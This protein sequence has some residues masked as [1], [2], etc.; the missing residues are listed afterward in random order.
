MNEKALVVVVGANIEIEIITLRMKF[1]NSITC[2]SVLRIV[3]CGG[4]FFLSCVMVLCLASVFFKKE[5]L[6]HLGDLVKG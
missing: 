6:L 4:L 3:S 5:D 2:I 1:D